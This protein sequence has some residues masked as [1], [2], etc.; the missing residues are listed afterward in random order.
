MAGG[1]PTR[2]TIHEKFIILNP[3]QENGRNTPHISPILT[4]NYCS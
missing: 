3:K 1:H 2:W 4:T